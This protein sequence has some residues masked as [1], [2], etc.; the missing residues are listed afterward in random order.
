MMSTTI[1]GFTKDDSLEK[2]EL[3]SKKRVSV[4]FC[5]SFPSIRNTSTTTLQSGIKEFLQSLVLWTMHRPVCQEEI[6]ILDPLGV[7]HHCE[8]TSDITCI[9]IIILF[10]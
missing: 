8:K 6:P 3:L 2:Q 1:K 10:H 5:V 4:E 7:P 9:S